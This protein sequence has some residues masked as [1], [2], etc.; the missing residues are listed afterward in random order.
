MKKLLCS[1][2]FLLATAECCAQSIYNSSGRPKGYRH[3]SQQKGYDPSKLVYGGDFNFGYS[4]DYAN[5]GVSPKLGY[6][7]TEFLAAGVGI[8]YQYSK[9]PYGYDINSKLLFNRANLIY[10]GLWVK[11]KVF[12]PVFVAVDMEY[13]LVSLKRDET[14]IDNYGNYAYRKTT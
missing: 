3:Y 13:A 12:D 2:V 8:G 6:R 5:F 10:P 14:Y 7:F 11:C 4:G 9:Y 1:L